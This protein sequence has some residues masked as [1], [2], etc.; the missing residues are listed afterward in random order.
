[1]VHFFLKPAAMNMPHLVG[2]RAVATRQ[3]VPTSFAVFMYASSPRK[4]VAEMCESFADTLRVPIWDTVY[5][6]AARTGSFFVGMAPLACNASIS[7]VS[8]PSCS[9]T[10]ALCSPSAGAR[11]AGTLVMPCT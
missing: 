1:M 2:M 3:S 11:L 5:P 10:S 6:A 7:L 9:R 4:S 8:N